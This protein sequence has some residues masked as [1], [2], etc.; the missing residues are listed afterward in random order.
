MGARRRGGGAAL[1]WAGLHR[2]RCVLGRTLAVGVGGSHAVH[3]VGP[4]SRVP[5]V[6]VLVAGVGEL[7]AGWRLLLASWGSTSTACSIRMSTSG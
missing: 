4:G 3:A 7:L 5:R 1:R 6:R 2:V